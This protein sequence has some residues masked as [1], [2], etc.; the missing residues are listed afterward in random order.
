MRVRLDADLREFA[1]YLACNTWPLG[2]DMQ[3]VPSEWSETQ[4]KRWQEVVGRLNEMGTKVA[5]GYR[6]LVREARLRLGMSSDPNAG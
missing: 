5:T 2:E 6:A 1:Y 3:S 4:S